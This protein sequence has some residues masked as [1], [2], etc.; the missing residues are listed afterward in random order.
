MFYVSSLSVEV[1]TFGNFIRKQRSDSGMCLSCLEKLQY[2]VL[3]FSGLMDSARLWVCVIEEEKIYKMTLGLQSHFSRQDCH[4]SPTRPLC[5]GPL[6]YIHT[7]SNS[8]PF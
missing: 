4:L 3:W 6:M 5:F 7:R 8:M 1:K 2:T